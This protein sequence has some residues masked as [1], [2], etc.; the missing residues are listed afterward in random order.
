MNVLLIEDEEWTARQTTQFLREYAPEATVLAV[1][2]SVE[3]A[4]DWFARNPMPDLIFSDIELLD[5]N[6]FTLYSQVRITCPI[7]FVTAYDQFLLQ[8]FKGNG[9]AYLLKPFDGGQFKVTLDKYYALRT[10]FAGQQPSA[11]TAPAATAPGLLDEAVVQE[12]SRA[13]QQNSRSYKQRFSVRMRNSL[14]ILPVDDVMY[15]Q[16][17]EG[18]VF[19][20]DKQAARYPLAGTLTDLEKQLDPNRF[21]RL[22]RSELI[23]I[24]Y[25]EKVEPYFGNRLSVKLKHH[26]TSLVTSAAQTADFRKWLE[27]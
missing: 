12:L 4:L 2:R 18:V 7:I 6:V 3:K 24:H 27:G 10:S 11:A 1:L 23:N 15:L 16:A 8:A 22:N 14:Y 26:E 20:C 5:G 13:L 25:V 9:I 19:A 21:F 17:D